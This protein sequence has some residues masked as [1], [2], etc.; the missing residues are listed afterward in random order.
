MTKEQRQ[1]DAVRRVSSTNSA[2]ISE[3]TYTHTHTN[4][5]TDLNNLHKN[6][7]K[8][9]IDLNAKGKT[10]NLL[11]GNIRENED[12]LG[13]D[14]TFLDTTQKMIYERNN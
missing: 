9:I 10:I 13:R 5:D 6:E 11:E 12:D 14:D 2:G 7:L 1:Y 8:C 3:Y 4:L